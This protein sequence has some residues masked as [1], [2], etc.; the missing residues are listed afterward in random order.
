MK[1][2]IMK[3]EFKLKNDYIELIKLLKV[4]GL[5]DTGGHA[6]IVVSEGMVTV[7]G[8]TELRKKCKIRQGQT[9]EFEGHSVVVI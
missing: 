4:V 3:T 2:Q 6:K 5:C 7:D 8:Q 9:I 1:T